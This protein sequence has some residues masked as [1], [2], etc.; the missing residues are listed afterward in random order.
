MPRWIAAPAACGV[1]LLAG[2]GSDDDGPAVAASATTARPAGAATYRPTSDVRSNAAIGRDVAAIRALLEPEQAGA[3]P[4]FAAAARIW[5]RG[6]S[7]KKSDGTNRTLAEF[8]EQ[9]PSAA[10]VADALEGDGTAAALTAEQ[11]VEWVDKGMVVAL[12][13]HA[14]EEF[15]G[16]AEK[17]AAGEL[18]PQEGA[19]HN[20]DEVWAYYAAGGEGVG[21]TADKRSADFGLGEHELHDDVIAGISAAQDAVEA[22]DAAKLAAATKRTRGA[23]NRIFALAVKKYAVEGRRDPKARAEG[24]AFSWGLAGELDDRDLETVQAA[25]RRADRPD[26]AETV[27]ATLDREAATLGFAGPLPAY[28]PAGKGAS[29]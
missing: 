20:V 19:I 4:D 14:L 1:L 5:E 21:A 13:V 16:A 9:H 26:A 11:R 15:D 28:P 2:C 12:K 24:V 17:L 27:A 22:K 7:S 3:K 8:V 25:L 29:S 18:D 10:R 6:R 23:M